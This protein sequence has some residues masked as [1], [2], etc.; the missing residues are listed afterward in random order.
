MYSV[1]FSYI[2]NERK[3]AVQHNTLMSYHVELHVSNSHELLSD[4]SF[5]NNFKIQAHMKMKL[6]S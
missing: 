1:A 2:I 3:Y 6:S 4:T 5:Y